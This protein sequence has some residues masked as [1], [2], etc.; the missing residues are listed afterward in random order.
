MYNPCTNVL[1][2]GAN[3]MNEINN[4]VNQYRTGLFIEAIP[5]V[6]K[7]LEIDSGLCISAAVARDKT[8]SIF[9]WIKY[10]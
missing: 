10:M 1:F 5:D 7:K 3:D 8:F 9:S 6:F 2:I 4:Y